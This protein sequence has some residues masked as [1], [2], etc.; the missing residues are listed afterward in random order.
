[1]PSSIGMNERALA[2]GR[3]VYY[4]HGKIEILPKVAV[5]SLDE[6][7][8]AYTPGVAYAVQEI[9]ARPEAHWEQTTKGNLI[10][11]ISDGSAVLGLGNAGP[12]AA[13][14]VMEGKAVMFKVLAGVD[15]IPLCLQV[16]NTE[17]LIETIAAL[18]PNFGAINLEDIAAPACFDVVSRLRERLSIPVLHDD[19]YGTAT[20][21]VAA[22]IN[23]LEVT[24]RNP[25]KQRVVINGAGAAGTATADLLLTLGL[26][27]VIMVDRRGILN[28]NATYDVAHFNSLAQRTNRDNISGD[29]KAALR[30]AD[31]FIGLSVGRLV[32]GDM[33]RTMAPSPIVFALA[34]P[35]PEIM[36]PEAEAAG[37]A[38]IATGRF[39]FPNQ[40]NNVLAFPAL[41]RGA[42]DVRATEIN[43]E[44]CL[45]A[46][47]AIAADVP[48]AELRHARILPTPFS[49]TLYPSV[50]E[51]VA[52]TAVTMGIATRDP[53]VG[54]V[55]DNCRHLRGLVAMRQ[56]ILFGSTG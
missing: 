1:M 54:A 12:M 30:G 28:R 43:N 38:V 26:G 2:F 50:A 7:A 3:D 42:L 21:V 19:Q 52:R 40:C 8:A 27:D 45:A 29:L 4:G 10:A 34:N 47:R 6:M 13:G 17:R 20:A 49:E 51:A 46:A 24:G 9:L 56:K 15:C 48:R 32:S 31:V 14:P 35:E 23:A 22:L 18:E 37:A 16:Q 5:R 53:G 41:I 44:M 36:P 25:E 11:L 55:A 33:V 39:D